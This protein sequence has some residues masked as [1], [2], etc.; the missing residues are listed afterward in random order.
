MTLISFTLTPPV[1]FDDQPWTQAL[2]QEATTETGSYTTVDTIT[3]DHADT[4]PAN[5]DP[6]EFTSDEATAGRWYRVIFQDDDSNQSDPTQSVQQGVFAFADA[7][8][9][10]LT[11]ILKVRDPS[12]DQITA[13]QRVLDA[14]AGEVLAEIGENATLEGWQQQLATE[15]CL[16]RAVEHWQQQESAF[17]L[18]GIGTEFPT[19]IARDTWDRHAAKLAPLKSSWGLA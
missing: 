17:G 14:S 2:I 8:V 3:F 9:G 5:P 15:V 4:D 6:Q 13:M 7:T 10:E 12:G 19:R 11:R 16:E 18:I 1:R